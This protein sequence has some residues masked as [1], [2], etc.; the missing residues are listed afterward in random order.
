[1]LDPKCKKCRRVGEKLFLKGER[2]FSQKCAMIRKP[3]RP[4][5]H[6]KSRRRRR[7][8]EYGQQL[9][10]KQKVRLLYGVSEKQFKNYVKAIAPKKGDKGELLLTNLETRLD[11]VIF[12]LGWAKSRA[13]AR[14]IVNHG[15]ILVNQ[16]KLDIP[17]YQ[18]KKGD[19]IQIKEKIKKSPIFKDL[20]TILNKYEAPSWL[21]LDKEKPEGQVLALPKTEDVGKVGEMGMIIE[22]Y[23]R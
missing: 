14:Q 15:H 17:S 9:I 12:R 11:N 18:V 10:E 7:L 3:Y 20:K 1:M 2:C 19:Q 4:G 22:F 8:S 13:L 6:G 5:L 23:S 21:G 16:R